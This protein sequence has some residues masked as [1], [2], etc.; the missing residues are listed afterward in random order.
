L[1]VVLFLL[2]WLVA[3]V[4]SP[5]A[6]FV[7]IVVIVADLLVFVLTGPTPLAPLS[8]LVTCVVWRGRGNAAPS[9]PYK[10]IFAF[11]VFSLGGDLLCG[12]G[13]ECMAQ[14]SFKIRMGT[15]ALNSSLLSVFRF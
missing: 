10:V 13:T 3:E 5:T 4:G 12:K 1:H 14:A 2:C 6:A 7:I 15:L 11:Y 8:T 9:F